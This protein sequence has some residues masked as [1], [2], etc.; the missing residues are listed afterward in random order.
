MNDT[1][2]TYE[3][4]ARS[5]SELGEGIDRLR[6]QR[7]DLL[8]ACKMGLSAL[9]CNPRYRENAPTISVMEAAVARA[10]APR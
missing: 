7:D 8:A 9:E 4:L 2:T 1:T 10:E 3:D 6:E 5:I